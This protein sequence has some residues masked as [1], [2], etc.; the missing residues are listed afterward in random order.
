[1]NLP[2]V[3]CTGEFMRGRHS[4]SF[5]KMLGVT[6]TIAMN[7]AEYIEIA[8]KL[9]MET[10]WRNIISQ[11]MSD[12][13]SNLYDDKDCVVGLEEFYKQVVE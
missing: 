2:I 1:C 11:R 5:L 4:D 6:D 10:N 13:H 7:E 3:T 9:G 8:V 12:S